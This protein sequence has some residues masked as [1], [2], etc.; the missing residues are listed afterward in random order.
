ME[1]YMNN[2]LSRAHFIILFLHSLIHLSIR[3]FEFTHSLTQTKVSKMI[4]QMVL[5]I[6]A[7]FSFHFFLVVVV[8]V[9]TT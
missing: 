2:R 1:M 3:Y 8:V 5:N 6:L 9:I 4:D 7:V